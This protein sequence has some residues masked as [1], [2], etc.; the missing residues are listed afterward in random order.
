[1]RLLV[2]GT[3]VLGCETI[4]IECSGDNVASRFHVKASLSAMNQSLQSGWTDEDEISIAID[5]RLDQSQAAIGSASWQRMLSGIVDRVRMEPLAGLVVLE[6]RD[7]TARLIDLPVEAGF[8]NKTSSEIAAL[9]AEQAGLGCV[10]DPTSTLVGQYYQIQHSRTSLATFSRHGNA[11]DLLCEL[12]DLEG[13]DVWVTGTDLNFRASNASASSS[14]DIICTAAGSGT[15]YSSSNVQSLTLGRAVGISAAS[16]VAVASWNSRQK[17]LVTSQY[18]AAEGDRVYRVVRPNLLQDEADRLAEQTYARLTRHERVLTA[19][20]PGEL[21]LAPRSTIGLQGTE[22][23]W[24][25][26]YEISR[27]ERIMSVEAGF[28]QTVTARKS[29]GF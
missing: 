23:D 1:M 11:W 6:G 4:E 27:I 20:M 9:L 8:L 10:A 3:I 25:G 19:T 18:P 21:V 22:T 28:R 26:L 17:H 7:L 5:F 16:T 13:Y 29:G 2:A 12:A 15:E 14:F 24:D